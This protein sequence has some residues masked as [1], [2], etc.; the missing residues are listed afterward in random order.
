MATKDELKNMLVSLVNLKV[1]EEDITEI[2]ITLKTKMSSITLVERY[3]ESAQVVKQE[4][5][6]VDIPVATT[7]TTEPIA[8]PVK[9][10]KKRI[11]KVTTEE[12]VVEIPVTLPVVEVEKPKVAETVVLPTK[13]TGIARIVKLLNFFC[14]GNNYNPADITINYLKEKGAADIIEGYDDTIVQA[15]IDEF[16]KVNGK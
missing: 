9:E 15:A 16:K 7:P 8:I 13:P 1:S 12:K 5:K 2:D 11:P 14:R 6:V 10:R 3:E 4:D